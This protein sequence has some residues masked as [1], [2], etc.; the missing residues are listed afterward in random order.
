MRSLG[1]VNVVLGITVV[2]S[3]TRIAATLLL[4][5]VMRLEGVFTGQIISWTVDMILSL[6]LYFFFYRTEVHLSKL[7]QRAR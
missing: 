7:L 3:I 2:G 6:L 4:V 1:R 5:P